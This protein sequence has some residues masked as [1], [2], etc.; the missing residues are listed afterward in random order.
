M[1]GTPIYDIKPY[2]PHVDAITDAKG[3]FAQQFKDYG[4]EVNFPNELLEMVPKDKREALIKVLSNDPRP[5]YQDDAERIYGM[6]FAGMNV[7]FLVKN[8]V[9]FVKEVRMIK[10]F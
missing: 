9:V 3:G 1:D 6:S 7:K 8:D 4:L 10:N 2:L 5:S